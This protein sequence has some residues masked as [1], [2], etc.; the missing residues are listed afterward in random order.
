[1]RWDD[2]RLGIKWPLPDPILS[3]RDRSYALLP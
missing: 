1:V 2:P 3:E